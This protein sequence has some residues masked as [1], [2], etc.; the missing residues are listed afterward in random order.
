M[1]NNRSNNN[2]RRG[3]GNNRQQGGQPVNRIDSRARGNA[4]Q[5]LEKYRKMAH[6]AHLNGDRVTEEYYLQFADHYFRV[7]ADQRQ[8]QE[9]SRPPRRED[10]PQ[11]YGDYYG[12]DDEGFEQAPQDR[13]SR[14]EPEAPSRAPEPRAAERSPAPERSAG[15]E[16]SN[17][18]ERGAGQEGPAPSEAEAEA[19]GRDDGE[20][21]D[22]RPVFEPA[23][24]P[25]VRDNRGTRGLNQR[26]P[27]GRP[28]RGENQHDRERQPAAPAQSGPVQSAETPSNASSGAA[29][30]PESLPP[31]ISSAKPARRPRKTAAPV[32]AEPAEVSAPEPAAEEKP[33]RRRTR[34]VDADGAPEAV[35]G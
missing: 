19:A 9:D 34:K 29:F 15:R 11:D 25:F 27:R 12:N 22:D 8:R 4:P 6:D 3:R 14:P 26:K 10:R 30:D 13:A 23:E 7:M 35:N 17:A 28:A 31:S 21:R 24:N 32:E 16:R 2:R 18:S 1:N 33:R 5:L 20:G